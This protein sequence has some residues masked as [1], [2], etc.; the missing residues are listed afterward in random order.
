MTH[1][2]SP[3]SSIT[4]FDF[5]DSANIDTK[6]H[7]IGKWYIPGGGLYVREMKVFGIVC[8][9]WLLILSFVV[10]PFTTMLIRFFGGEQFS[11]LPR[12]AMTFL[13]PLII[14]LSGRRQLKH[15]RSFNGKMLS[16]TRQLVDDPVHL[17][18]R[19]VR[20][21]KRDGAHTLTV[22]VP[23]RTS[24]GPAPASRPTPGTIAVTEPGH[25]QLRVRPS[26]FHRLAGDYGPAVI[27]AV[28]PLEMPDP[29][30]A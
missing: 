9:V 22:W 24:A 23:D 25:H 6:V 7:K 15:G 4:L 8:V 10:A 30:A 29:V 12:L 17:R 2:S 14:A 21:P 11:G 20:R 5:T 27:E 16:R 1:D 13:P 28:A 26:G 18:G 19:P 3:V